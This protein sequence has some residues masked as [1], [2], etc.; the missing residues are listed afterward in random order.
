[1]T[2]IGAEKQKSH[3]IKSDLNYK[4]V[5]VLVEKPLEKLL[6]EYHEFIYMSSSKLVKISLKN[7]RQSSA[8]L[9]T[10]TYTF[11]RSHLEEVAIW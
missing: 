2:R 6:I 5:Y 10:R 1:M 11:S 8:F 4:N 7:E 3:F 9:A